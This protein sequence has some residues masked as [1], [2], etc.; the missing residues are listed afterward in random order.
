ME[1]SKALHKL[2]EAIDLVGMIEEIIS[3]STI[4]KM[5]PSALS[6]VR[7]TLRN[8]REMIQN[9]HSTLSSEL[10]ARSRATVTSDSQ[11]ASTPEHSVRSPRNYSSP[12]VEVGDSAN[13]LRTSAAA[14]SPVS[15]TRRELKASLEKLV[16]R[17]Q[18]R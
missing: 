17:E 7:I 6:G 12:A 2:G 14:H 1:E 16:D 8:V 10:V 3:P 15:I 11:S 13:S 5:N 4:D 9:S 18:A